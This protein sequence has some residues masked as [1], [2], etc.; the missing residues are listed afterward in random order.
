MRSMNLNWYNHGD[1]MEMTALSLNFNATKEE[2]LKCIIVHKILSENC[3][4]DG[5]K[6]KR[7][8]VNGNLSQKL[9]ADVSEYTITELKDKEYK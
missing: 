3:S 7:N 8:I 4:T 9:S 6:L 5:G 2:E 1:Y